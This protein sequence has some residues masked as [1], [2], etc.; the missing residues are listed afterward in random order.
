MVVVHKKG[1]YDLVKTESDFI[2]LNED[3]KKLLEEKK[4]LKFS[5]LS[6]NKKLFEDVNINLKLN[7]QKG[8]PIKTRIISFNEQIQ[9]ILHEDSKYLTIP[10][11]D[12]ILVKFFEPTQENYI[13]EDWIAL[14]GDKPAQSLITILQ[15]RSKFSTYSQLVDIEGKKRYL[16]KN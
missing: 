16:F 3:L 7:F 8:T 10:A 2:K 4:K 15:I 9:Q 1:N 14:G 11:A 6:N 5:A 13:L 12:E